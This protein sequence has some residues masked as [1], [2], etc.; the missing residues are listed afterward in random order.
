VDN[1]Q[2]YQVAKRRK[3]D[4]QTLTTESCEDLQGH[5]QFSSWQKEYPQTKCEYLTENVKVFVTSGSDDGES[6]DRILPFS[7]F[8]S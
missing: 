8:L 7:I 2:I 1:I 5:Q 6:D 4:D 3:M